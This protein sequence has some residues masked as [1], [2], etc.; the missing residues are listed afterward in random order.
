MTKDSAWIGQISIHLGSGM[1]LAFL[2]N[3]S[4]TLSPSPRSDRQFRERNRKI[5]SWSRWRWN[6]YVEPHIAQ[7]ASSQ[8]EDYLKICGIAP[9]AMIG[10]ATQFVSR[11]RRW[12]EPDRPR[13]PGPLGS[14]CPRIGW[15]QER[16]PAD[17]G[18]A[19]IPTSTRSWAQSACSRLTI[20]DPSQT[21]SDIETQ[22]ILKLVLSNVISNAVAT[23]MPRRDPA[24][25]EEE[26]DA[27]WQ[28]KIPVKKW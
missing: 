5:W 19:A 15:R 16:Y 8:L 1:R 23:W 2:S 20:V 14:L 24:R 10:T 26:E 25:L 22:R 7:D 11:Y 6:S 3:R 21:S 12:D 13:N 9:A 28:L 27:L 4:T 18:L 17:Q